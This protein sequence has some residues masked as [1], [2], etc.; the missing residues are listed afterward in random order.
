MCFGREGVEQ[1][2]AK[3]PAE[4]I[5]AALVKMIP[6][7]FIDCSAFPFSVFTFQVSQQFFDAPDQG[8]HP[9]A[10]ATVFATAAALA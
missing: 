7:C 8:F 5:A 3:R 10:R 6:I 4:I 1:P 2:P 9:F